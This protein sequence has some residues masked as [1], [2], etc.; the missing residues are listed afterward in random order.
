MTHDVDNISFVIL[1]S[2]GPYQ[3]SK[4]LC[5]NR[6][7]TKLPSDILALNV[8]I[9]KVRGTSCS[10]HIAPSSLESVAFVVG[11][12]RVLQTN[13]AIKLI[14]LQCLYTRH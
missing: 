11:A 12:R 7:A 3:A 1:C 9:E 5:P 14:A 6:R 4:A 2:K 8:A 13:S 10:S